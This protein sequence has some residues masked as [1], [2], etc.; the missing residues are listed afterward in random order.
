M[1]SLGIGALS[2]ISVSL[3]FY[4]VISIYDYQKS[5]NLG[6][7]FFYDWS[8]DNRS[9]AATIFASG[10]S[11][12]TVVIALLDLGRVF[13]TAVIWAPIT[14]CFGWFTLVLAAPAI[15]R[16][17][18]SHDTLHT[19]LGR[20]Y[21]SRGLVLVSSWATTIGFV[22][23]FATEILAGD[24]IFTSIGLGKYGATIGIAIFALVTIIYSGVGGF[25]SVIR[26]D[27]IQTWLLLPSLLGIC[28][29]AVNFFL[30][31]AE[32]SFWSSD[33]LTTYTLPVSVFVSLALINIA[34]PI[35]D[36]S[37][38]QRVRAADSDASFQAG[39]IVAIAG[40]A[41]TWTLLILLG[42]GMAP[43]IASG[44]SPFTELITNGG[45]DSDI[46]NIVLG[47]IVF[48]GLVAAMLSTA[49]TFLN[50]AG[51]T[52]SLD[53]KKEQNRVSDGNQARATRDIIIM[54]VAGFLGALVFREIGFSIVD[55]IFAVYGGTLA[56]CTPIIFSLYIKKEGVERYSQSA[57]LA[58][59]LGFVISWGNGIYSISC[60][61]S[62]ADVC[63]SIGEVWAPDIFMSPVL[64]FFVSLGVFILSFI[65]QKS[66]QT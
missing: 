15:R 64:A 22:G 1:S 62:S 20:S 8:L 27:S 51:H 40:F 57:L 23:T 65:F 54:G 16:N 56:L 49:D 39:G 44:S 46:K 58:V 29:F 3:I 35:A 34:F 41:I 28:I 2:A 32:T 14:Y 10:M 26:S 9:V 21:D 61:E 13:G 25:R 37:A 48:P 36:M 24:V 31:S 11:L 66:I 43:S 5:Q 33:L 19:F 30:N 63:S 7:Y 38:W 52:Y 17:T 42:A 12:A 55:M 18:R 50:A 59:I 47:V 4:L 60:R 6:D 45:Y 53:I